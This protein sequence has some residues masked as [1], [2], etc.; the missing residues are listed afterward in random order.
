MG[1]LNVTPDSFSDGGAFLNVDQAVSAGLQ[2]MED[3]ADLIDVGGESTRPGATPVPADEELRRIIPAI[4]ELAARGVPISV[5]TR[6]AAVARG[7]LAA[8]A[9]LVN[10]VSAMREPEMAGVIASSDAWVCLMHMQGEPETMQK[11]PHYNNVVG[12]VCAFLCER[13][14]VA[15]L[16]GIVREKIWLDPGIGFGKTDDHN[17]TLLKHLDKLVA[18]GYPVV[19]GVSRKGFLGR[20][21]AGDKP[22]AVAERLP[23]ALA[24]QSRA[25]L[26]GVR[27]IR[28]H[29]VRATGL[30]IRATTQMISD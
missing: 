12:E 7:A 8:G 18:S 5:D 22:L 11:A 10:D 30:T 28:T 20:L 19:L 14:R 15:E 2:M 3:G 13:A 26:A 24:I 23:A 16:A 27:V 21:A 9:F 17:F 25:Q 29:D 1:V 6:K 4:T